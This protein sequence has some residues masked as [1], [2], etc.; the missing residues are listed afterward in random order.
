MV[1]AQFSLSSAL[2]LPKQNGNIL[3][4]KLAPTAFNGVLLWIT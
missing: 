3:S 1:L 2:G 4:F